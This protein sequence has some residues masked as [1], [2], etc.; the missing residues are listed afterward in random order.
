MRT[1]DEWLSLARA[2]HARL[3]RKIDKNGPPHPTDP[4]KGCCWIYLAGKDH[5][6]YGKFAITAPRGETP[7]Q[8]HVRAHRIAYELLHG[9]VPSDLYLLHS[10]DRPACA[11]PGHLSPG[12]AADNYADAKKRGRN[13]EGE[14]HGFARNPSLIR[15]GAAHPRASLTEAQVIQI[16]ERFAAGETAAELARLFGVDRGKVA[17]IVHGTTWASVGGPVVPSKNRQRVPV[18]RDGVEH[19]P[20]AFCR[21]FKPRDAYRLDSKGYLR[22]YCSRACIVGARDRCRS[23]WTPMK[24]QAA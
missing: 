1:Y 16:R 22:S 14:R 2:Q 7:K 20:C 8:K 6:G 4:N 19:W 18:W 17:G 9:Q 24:E 12:T 23:N 10:C 15:R 11:N 21:K 13:T 3:W 5:A